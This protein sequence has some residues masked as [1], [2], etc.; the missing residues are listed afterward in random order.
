MSRKKNEGLGEIVRELADGRIIDRE[1]LGQ[2]KI[3]LEHNNGEYMIA[4]DG[5]QAKRKR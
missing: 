3:T 1:E 2:I 4:K 5:E